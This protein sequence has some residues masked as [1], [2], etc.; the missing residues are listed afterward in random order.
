M[1]ILPK[2]ERAKGKFYSKKPEIFHNNVS[3][4]GGCPEF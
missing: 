2:N 1:N 4:V 3:P